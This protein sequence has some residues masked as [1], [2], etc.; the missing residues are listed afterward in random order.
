MRRT[1]AG[2]F[3]GLAL[4]ALPVLG[5]DL[6]KARTLDPKTGRFHAVHKNEDLKCESCH[7]KTQEDILLLRRDEMPREGYITREDC[8]ACH[9]APDKPAFY[10]LPKR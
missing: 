10:G 9:K 7:S 5:A 2:V 4:A 6:P 1:F 8:L 3:L